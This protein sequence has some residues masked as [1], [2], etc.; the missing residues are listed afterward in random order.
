MHQVVFIYKISMEEF[1]KNYEIMVLNAGKAWWPSDGI[2]KRYF[3][4][5]YCS[6]I[7]L[8]EINYICKYNYLLVGV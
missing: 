5:L 1:M 7:I 4:S 8:Y 6:V 2:L 3:I